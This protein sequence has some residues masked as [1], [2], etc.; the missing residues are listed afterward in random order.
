MRRGGKR[1]YSPFATLLLR[2]M[3][4]LEDRKR[5]KS[6]RQ[7]PVGLGPEED[8]QVVFQ[9]PFQSTLYSSQVRTRT[10]GGLAGGL[11]KVF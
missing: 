10:R 8:A 7:F 11:S 9:K 4:S 5:E 3:A 1:G 6:A 2:R